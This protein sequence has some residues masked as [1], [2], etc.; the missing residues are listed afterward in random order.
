MRIDFY[1]YVHQCQRKQM[2][3]LAMHAGEINYNEPEKLLPLAEELAVFLTGIRSHA[4]HEDIFIHPLLRRK[5]P[6]ASRTLDNEHEELKKELLNL[7]ENFAHI[8]LLTNHYP[9][10]QEQGLEFYRALNRFIANYLYHIDKEEYVMQN[11]WEIAAA[12]ELSG[13]MMA[14]QVYHDPEEGRKWLSNHLPAMNFDERVLM[15]K[16]VELM[17]P[18]SCFLSMSKISE[19]ILGDNTWQSIKQHCH[20]LIA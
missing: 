19:E 11:L 8:Q 3:N 7:E 14:F 12:P 13:M 20:Q 18:A 17:A 9:K 16:T 5:M 6:S 4:D 2:F 1:T 15:F 10:R